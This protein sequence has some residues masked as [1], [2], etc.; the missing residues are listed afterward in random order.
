MN[1]ILRKITATTLLGLMVSPLAN[2]LS[3]PLPTLSWQKSQLEEAIYKKVETTLDRILNKNEYTIDVA[4]EVTEPEIP[5]WNKTDT[6]NENKNSQDGKGRSTASE[7]SA[8]NDQKKAQERERKKAEREK[9]REEQRIALEKRA[10]EEKK[11]LEEERKA[12]EN[13]KKIQFD[14]QKLPDTPED[15]IVFNKFGLEAPLVDDFNDL[16]PDGKIVLNMSAA[17]DAAQNRAPASS[18]IEDELEDQI[19]EV[20]DERDNLFNQLQSA[21]TAT[22]RAKEEAM[23]KASQTSAIEKMWK[24]NQAVDIYKNLTKVDILVRISQSLSEEQRQSAEKYIKDIN[25][26]LGEVKP[27]IKVEYV[28]LGKDFEEKNNPWADILKVLSVFGQY[29]TFAGIVL[30]VILFSIMAR[31]LIAKYHELNS[32]VSNSGSFTMQ[33][34][35]QDDDKSDLGGGNGSGSQAGGLDSELNLN[36]NGVE[37]FKNFISHSKEDAILLVKKWLKEKSSGQISA[38]KALV[39]QMDNDSLK[40]I[41]INLSENEKNEWRELLEEGLTSDELARAN[42]YIGNQII[43]NIMVPSFIKD[44]NIYSK[45]VQL[46]P[47]QFKN[48][49]EK[50]FNTACML[51]SLMSPDFINSVFNYFDEEIQQKLILGSLDITP[52]HFE[53][54]QDRISKALS[55]LGEED[56]VRPFLDGMAKLIP[57][58]GRDVERLLYTNFVKEAPESRVDFILR[59]YFPG[60]LFSEL[61]VD[62]I[63]TIFNSYPMSKRVKLLKSLPEDVAEFY[64]DIF[65]PEGTKANDLIQ[66]EFETMERDEALMK[67]IRINSDDYWREFIQF[68]RARLKAEK[69]FASQVDEVVFNWREDIAAERRAAA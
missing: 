4:L 16:Q 28:K 68:V 11:K 56:K 19:E 15:F 14:D 63:K 40:P 27:K 67:E 2:N 46:K 64:L 32:G 43:Q 7:Q 24:Y 44:P 12:A 20:E 38:L 36:I 17:Q 3:Q 66:I 69:Q 58:A 29:A 22:E 45:I 1:K 60:F 13:A 5:E 52:D 51:L 61:S 57:T 26:N 55:F 42:S 21:K 6:P 30:G 25:F 48:I 18:L 35:K 39:Q 54:G 33:S 49:V 53:K 8:D 41:L 10:E 50:D 37:R 47:N 34:D 65:A 62:I 9:K 59:E 23:K 31:G